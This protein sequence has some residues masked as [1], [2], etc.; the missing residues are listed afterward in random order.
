MMKWL[1]GAFA[2]VAISTGHAQ[3]VNGVL[4]VVKGEVQI[5]SSKT[6]Q[7]TRAKLGQQVFPKD[8]IITG[9][10]ARAKIVM[11]DN[12]EINVSPESQI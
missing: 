6:G 8:V 12:N 7:T 11:V 10:D 4:R 3:N 2:L 1:V 9:K 5:K